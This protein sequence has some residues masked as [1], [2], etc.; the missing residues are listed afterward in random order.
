[1]RRPNGPIRL[2]RSWWREEQR[3]PIQRASLLRNI[4]LCLLVLTPLL[5][6]Q[7]Q[8]RTA[9]LLRFHQGERDDTLALMEAALSV[10]TRGAPDWAHWD[11]TYRFARG[12][13]PDFEQ[14]SLATASLFDAGAVVVMLRPDGSPLLT[15]AGPSF[16]LP[17]DAALIRCVKDNLNQLPTPTSRVR[18]ACDSGTGAIYLGTATPISNNGAKATAA[19]TLALFD[20]LLKPEYN[21]RI[22]QRLETLRRELVFQPLS[23]LQ[24]NG[25]E[26]PILPKIHSSANRVLAIR[27][28][29]VLPLVLQSLSA[30]L[31]LLIAV[32]L[33]AASIRALQM[34]ERRRQRIGQRLVER[35]ANQRIQQTCR[36]LDQ[37]IDGLRP[38]GRSGPDGPAILGRLSLRSELEPSS[39]DSE[40]PRQLQLSQ[41]EKVTDRFQRFLHTASNLALFDSLT[42]LP[43][44][45]YF[46]EHLA[47]ICNSHPERNQPFA[48]LFLDVDKFK[49]INDTYGHSVGDDVLVHVSQRLRRLMSEGDFIARYGGDELAVILDLSD[50]KDQSLAQLNT[51]ARQRAQEMVISMQEPV[52][53]G[54]ISIAISLSIGITL[55]DPANPDITSVMQRS[56]LAMYQAKSS[57]G[58][59]IIGP[60]DVLEIPQLSNYQLF[61]DLIKAIR[62]QQLQVFFQAIADSNGKR[63]GVEA[64][65]RWR[66]D[67]RGWIEPTVFLEM[68]E[69]HRQM[70]LLGKELIRLS[71]D[72]FQQLQQHLPDLRLYLNLAPAQLLEPGLAGNLLEQ[73]HNRRL[74]ADQLTLELT[75]HSVL[76]PHPV[77]SGNLQQLRQAG[78]QLALD[79]FGTGYSSLLLL[80]SIR[81]DVVKID[82]SFTQ[83]IRSDS[84][85]LHIINLIADLAPRL[86]LELVAE[87]IEDIAT[88]Q[89]LATLGIQN[90][91]GYALGRPAPLHDWLAPVGAVQ[92]SSRS[93]V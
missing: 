1:M 64:L 52:A 77:V 33:L 65:A 78:V 42:Q 59:R 83:S 26:T 22:R 39:R 15:H 53:I 31:P 16:R 93:I 76:E 23:S 35:R 2:L 79:D 46:L 63:R 19:G 24:S 51:A 48:I 90:F 47:E 56:D 91:Q 60:D 81:P 84:E 89:L 72:G 13:N 20:P 50:L 54:E 86:G 82:K 5:V 87:G 3:T 27:Q 36:Q 40:S 12:S 55:V 43:N 21:Q 30:D 67:T 32:P 70:T 8:R 4:G 80:K 66:H 61:T 74:G 38:M 11:D 41:L 18:L 44:R 45:R 92:P 58:S 85:A 9:A 37:L 73:L 29:P 57:R 49:F 34:L 28:Q 71:L 69:Q 25:A 7:M 75:E 6:L 62:E 17:S 10:T 68:A 14:N 88:L